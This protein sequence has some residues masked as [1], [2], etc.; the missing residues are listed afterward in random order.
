[1]TMTRAKTFATTPT[2]LAA[3]LLG[4]TLFATGCGDDD[5]DAPN[6]PDAALADAAD[7]ID[8]S[9]IDGGDDI[10]AGGPDAFMPIGSPSCDEFDA[11]VTTLSTFPGT[12]EGSLAQAE[13]NLDV[14]DETECTHSNSPFGQAAAGPDQVIALTGLTAGTKYFAK[15]TSGGDLNVYVVTGCDPAAPGP[16]A[17]QCLGYADAQTSDATEII[18]F[19]APKDGKAFVVVDY[20]TVDE[21]PASFDYTLS[22]STDGCFADADCTTPQEP[23][24]LPAGE[25]GTVDFCVG[26]DTAAEGQSDDTIFGATVVSL[27]GAPVV[28]DAH[29]CGDM[30]NQTLEELDFYKVTVPVGGAFKVDVQWADTAADI[31]VMI[32]DESGKLLG[33]SFYQNPETVTM[34]YLAAGNYY[35]RVTRFAPQSSDV[36]PYTITVT[37]QPTVLCTTLADCAAG[38]EKEFFRASCNGA[39][40][41]VALEGAAAVALGDTCDSNDDCGGTATLCTN[42]PFVQ[43][44]DTHAVCSK[45]CTGDGDCAAVDATARCTTGFN[46]NICTMP[47]TSDLDCPVLINDVPAAGQPWTHTTCIVAEGRCSQ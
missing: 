4:A 11:P 18:D 5:D 14:T 24:C 27:A 47:C 39:G 9:D 31:D 35:I 42:F 10:D 15:M 22:V 41:C 13:A 16:G 43:H 32:I 30:D 38:F 19:I 17:G 33:E 7:G 2:T 44:A 23:I 36:T 20:Y 40:A 46:Q 12:Y 28:I 37:P 3:L 45:N 25:C 29:I 34:H 21:P 1:M 8:A 6:N 26:D